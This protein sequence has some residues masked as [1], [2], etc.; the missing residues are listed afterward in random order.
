M[1]QECRA[2]D[3]AVARRVTLPGDFVQRWSELLSRD[4]GFISR[5]GVNSMPGMVW[6]RIQGWC[7][8]NARDGVDSMPGMGWI[9]CQGW[10]DFKPKDWMDLCTIVYGV[11][12]REKF[13]C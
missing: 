2:F 11:R 4:S 9:Q 1:I 13:S 10:G 8:F 12:V 3:T 7:G 5:D 6:I